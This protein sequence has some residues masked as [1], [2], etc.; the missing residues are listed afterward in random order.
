MNEKLFAEKINYI[1]KQYDLSASAFADRIGVG[2]SS[3]SHILSGR[4]K[5]SLD[6]IIKIV[7]E[8]PDINLYW[9]IDE[10]EEFLLSNKPTHAKK[11]DEKRKEKKV[12]PSSPPLSEIDK[13]VIFYKDGSFESFENKD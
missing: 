7:E 5:P 12:S 6:F 2:R 9:L 13:I 8:F 10:E 11:S 4:N 1:L 3:I